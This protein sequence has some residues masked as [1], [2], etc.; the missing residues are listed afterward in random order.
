MIVNSCALCKHGLMIVA[1][2]WLLL[3]G[4]CYK[5]GLGK[6]DT[7]DSEWLGV[8]LAEIRHQRGDPDGVQYLENG[9][10]VIQY[11]EYS[12]RRERE[13]SLL[14]QGDTL[15]TYAELL[16]PGYDPNKLREKFSP[17]VD[18]RTSC[19]E[20]MFVNRESVIYHVGHHGWK[21]SGLHPF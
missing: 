3:L 14:Q 12:S 10:M 11:N 1:C 7:I 6:I 19:I 5:S 16:E 2:I 9:E 20:I 15:P 21:C 8:S 17:P 13:R 18:Y 4:G